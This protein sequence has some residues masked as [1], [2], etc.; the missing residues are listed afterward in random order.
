MVRLWRLPGAL[1]YVARCHRRTHQLSGDGS[2]STLTFLLQ[3]NGGIK[4]S[5]LRVLLLLFSAMDAEFLR[6]KVGDK[7]AKAVAAA[8]GGLDEQVEGAAAQGRHVLA[9]SQL[10]QKRQ[11]AA[12][13]DFA[14]RCRVAHNEVCCRRIGQVPGVACNGTMPYIHFN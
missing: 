8:C 11:C 14:A 6:G 7:L 12:R 9:L 5:S 4:T 2:R 13:R 3:L 1:L 10:R